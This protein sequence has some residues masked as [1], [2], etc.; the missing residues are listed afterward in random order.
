MI[1]WSFSMI[2][3]GTVFL[4]FIL[5]GVFWASWICCWYLT[6]IWEKL[7][8]IALSIASLPFFFLLV[9]ILCICYTFYGCPIVLGYS[10]LVF[11]GVFFWGGSYPQAQRSFPQRCPSHTDDPVRD[12]LRFFWRIV[13]HFFSFFFRISVWISSVEEP[14]SI[15]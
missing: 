1:F 15:M 7:V 14:L 8:F 4:V 2:W 6:L 12:I 10:V 9:F 11:F 5:L 3:T 13:Q